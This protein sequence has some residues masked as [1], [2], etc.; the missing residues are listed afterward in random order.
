MDRNEI[1]QTKHT[2]MNLIKHFK[3]IYLRPGPVED[4]A[5]R[6]FGVLKLG[7]GQEAAADGSKALR[8]GGVVIKYFFL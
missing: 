1:Y 3:C 6:C 4:G 7:R 2:L 8:S 5:W